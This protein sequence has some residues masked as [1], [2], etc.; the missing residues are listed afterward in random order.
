MEGL[1]LTDVPGEQGLFHGLGAE[2]MEGQRQDAALVQVAVVL[3]DDALQLGLRARRGL[4]P[5]QRV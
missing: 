1:D 3:G 5:E 4:V 2:Q